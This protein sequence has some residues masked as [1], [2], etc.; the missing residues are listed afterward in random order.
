[1][2]IGM[3]CIMHPDDIENLVKDGLLKDMK[4]IGRII[5]G[6]NNVLVY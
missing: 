2:G 5:K 4:I 3:V 1:M 6:I